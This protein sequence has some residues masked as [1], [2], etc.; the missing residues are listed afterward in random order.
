M[1]ELNEEY[2]EKIKARYEKIEAYHRDFGNDAI[3]LVYMHLIGMVMWLLNDEIEEIPGIP[4]ELNEDFYDTGKSNRYD[5]LKR[6]DENTAKVVQKQETIKVECP[7]CG[8]AQNLPPHMAHGTRICCGCGNQ[9]TTSL[10][11]NL[12]T[13][14]RSTVPK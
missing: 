10:T 1:R 9:F 2:L 4:M 8:N 11:D 7:E 12:E 5:D 14:D 3:V 6:L 13:F